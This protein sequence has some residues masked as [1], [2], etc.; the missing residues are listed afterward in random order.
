MA[1]DPTPG[2]GQPWPA[3]A[4]GGSAREGVQR[5]GTAMLHAAASQ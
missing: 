4:I 5:P 2:K 3:P 1:L